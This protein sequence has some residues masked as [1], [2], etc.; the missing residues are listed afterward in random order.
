MP[1]RAIFCLVPAFV[2]LC[3]SPAMAQALPQDSIDPAKS[4]PHFS[5]QDIDDTLKTVTGNHLVT[6]T[7]EGEKYISAFS[8]QGLQFTIHFHQCEGEENT[9]CKAIQLLTSWQ[10]DDGGEP[11]DELLIASAPSSLFVNLGRLPQGRPYMSRI[12]IAGQGISQGN[13]AE[14]IRLF[15]EAAILFDGR[16]RELVSN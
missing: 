1:A 2:L 11:L 8:P 16:I 4:L 14:E 6:A 7:A 10:V 15:L 12:V 9:Q 5:A 13:L 3:G